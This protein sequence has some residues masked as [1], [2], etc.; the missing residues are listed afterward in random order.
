MDILL[1]LS[2]WLEHRTSQN[3]ATF[4][5]NYACQS[6]PI[7]EVVI[8]S[9]R[10]RVDKCPRERRVKVHVRATN[11]TE[12]SNF[13]YLINYLSIFERITSKRH[14]IGHA[15][16]AYSLSLTPVSNFRLE[17]AASG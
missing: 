3:L 2:P 6:I 9:Q 1:T 14:A 12:I 11:R 15:N 5:A 7:N 17:T 13:I 8:S 16:S 4:G 10:E